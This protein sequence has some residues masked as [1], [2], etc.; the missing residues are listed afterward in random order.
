MDLVRVLGDEPSRPTYQHYPFPPLA[1]QSATYLAAASQAPLKPDSRGRCRL[2]SEHTDSTA[3]C[4]RAS[5]SRDR[6]ASGT[7]EDSDDQRRS[8]IRFFV[9][10]RG[11]AVKSVCVDRRE[12][13]QLLL[14]SFGAKDSVL[15]FG[16]QHL[17]E[18]TRWGD[19]AIV[20]GSVVEIWPAPA[21]TKSDPC[22]SVPRVPLSK[23]HQES[24]SWY[25]P[26]ATG[27]SVSSSASDSCSD[28]GR[29][30]ALSVDP[31][32]AEQGEHESRA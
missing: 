13:V 14:E 32:S 3:T 1:V 18:G 17:A 21:A 29:S 22:I 26:V 7:S 15:V 11:E 20:A 19:Y 10:P 23:L 24:Q 8:R 2:G 6:L 5:R 25:G 16:T 31:V 27:E 9:K 28:S 4:S 12:E 30:A